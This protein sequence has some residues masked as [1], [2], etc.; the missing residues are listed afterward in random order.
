MRR[1]PEGRRY[2]DGFRLMRQLMRQ[3]GIDDLPGDARI[4]KLREFLGN[5]D[6]KKAA[7]L[8]P[9][10]PNYQLAIRDPLHQIPKKQ[11]NLQ[12]SPDN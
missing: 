1:H 5:I 6:L 11:S 10:N 9:D 4:I 12:H 8:K 3:M 2:S 7:E